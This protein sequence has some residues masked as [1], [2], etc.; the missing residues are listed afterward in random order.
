[1]RYLLD[2]NA[3]IALLGGDP[4]FLE[5]LRAC[6]P[7]DVAMSAIVGHE[8]YYGAYK[9]RR[10]S[11]NLGRIEALRFPMLEFDR[12]DARAA[13]SI[14]AELAGSGRIIGPY[15]VLI[16]GQAVARGLTLISRNTREFDRVPGLSLENWQD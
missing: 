8:L 3:V 1:M 14:R 10:T 5:R 12:D 9:G 15:D 6:R 11:D 16:A 2:T 4:A 13:G 7:S